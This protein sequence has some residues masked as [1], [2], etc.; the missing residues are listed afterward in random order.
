VLA[1]ASYEVEGAELFLYSRDRHLFADSSLSDYGPEAA[2]IVLQRTINV[3]N[4]WT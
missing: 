1:A 4:R 3:L 2:K